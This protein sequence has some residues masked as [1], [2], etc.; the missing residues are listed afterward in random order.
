[1]TAAVLGGGEEVADGSGVAS[2]SAAIDC[3]TA[4][5]LLVLLDLAGTSFASLGLFPR[6]NLTNDLSICAAGGGEGD[7]VGSAVC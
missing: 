5:G 2:A 3:C 7:P 6:P 4:C 1:L